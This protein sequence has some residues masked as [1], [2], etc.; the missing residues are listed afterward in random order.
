MDYGMKPAKNFR[1]LLAW[2]AA[3]EPTLA[4][5]KVTKLFPRFEDLGSSSQIKRASVSITSNNA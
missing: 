2:Q 4:V 1:D 3:Y 5:Y